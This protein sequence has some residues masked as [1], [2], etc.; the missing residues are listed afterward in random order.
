M[1]TINQMLTDRDAAG[2][3]YAAALTEL[4]AAMVDL[5]A[6]DAALANRHHGLGHNGRPRTFSG[7]A[8]A[9]PVAFLHPDYAMDSL[10][11]IKDDVAAQEAAYL[12]A[13]AAG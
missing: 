5:A 12:D 9:V 13:L 10:G 3:R 2:A 4:R 7:E 1:T 11:G 8:N 6:M